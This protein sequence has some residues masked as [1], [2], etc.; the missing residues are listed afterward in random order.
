MDV[1]TGPLNLHSQA[2]LLPFSNDGSHRTEL[3]QDFSVPHSDEV[4]LCYFSWYINPANSLPNPVLHTSTLHV[5][6]HIYIHIYSRQTVSFF[7]V[8]RYAGRFKLGPK[9]PNFTLDLVSNRS[10]ILA[11]YVSSGIITHMYL[12]SF[13]YILDY[14]IPE[15]STR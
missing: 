14:R 4:T 5:Y 6:I 7:S 10:A 8:A 9:L 12:L 2:I 15:C 13:N 3:F 1:S 11:T